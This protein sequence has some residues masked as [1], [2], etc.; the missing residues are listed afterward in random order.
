MNALLYILFS[1]LCGG[2]IFFNSHSV[3]DSLIVSKWLF[4]GISIGVFILFLSLKW[5]GPNDWQRTKP[6]LAVLYATILFLCCFQ[7]I[8]GILQAFGICY[9][10]SV[11]RVAGSFDNPAGFAVCLCVGL[12]FAYPFLKSCRRRIKWTAWTIVCILCTAICLSQSRTGMISV[13]VM[14]GCAFYFY[15]PPLR[16]KLVYLMIVLATVLL[17]S[18][19]LKINSANGRL[20]VWKCT[21][22]MIVEHPFA[23]WGTRAFATHYMDYQAAYF[24]EYPQSQFAL[25][26][27][28]VNCPF[29]EYLGCC[30]S[31]GCFALI[32]VIV[33]GV[34]L[35]YCYCKRPSS[36]GKSA[37]ISL[38]G[39]GVFSF[40]SYPFSYPFTW[41][42]MALSSCVLVHQFYGHIWISP[43]KRRSIA[44][45][46]AIISLYLIYSVTTR[47]LVEREWKRVSDISLMEQTKKVLPLYEELMTILGDNPFFLY[48]YAAEL[49][50]FG[51]YEKCLQLLNVC[52]YYW[53]S[54]DLEFLFG[55]TY[56]QL[57]HYDEAVMHFQLASEMCPVKFAPLYKLYLIYKEQDKESHVRSLAMQIVCK[58]VKVPSLEI[59]R[60]KALMEKELNK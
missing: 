12:P 59:N 11:Y 13:L 22:R 7:A 21:C 55:E 54:Y 29:N 26:A 1:L 28:N 4:F 24:R 6:N 5:L 17:G 56:L 14:A 35:F 38:L 47:I 53:A 48:N 46:T 43:R 34:F 39:I 31:Y 8:Y 19:F 51:K 58:K 33:A 18:Y 50:V 16:Y 57:K 9:S 30:L 36:K 2:S 20:L 32:G 49:Y 27:D 37:G 45:C 41:I 23:G 52:R 3:N 42:I 15:L 60:M 40:F 25:L 10:E 44:V